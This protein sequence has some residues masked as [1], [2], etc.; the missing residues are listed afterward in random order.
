MYCRTLNTHCPLVAPEM[1][2]TRSL[3]PVMFTDRTGL[4]ERLLETCAPALGSSAHPVH[5][6]WPCRFE[7]TAYDSKSSDTAPAAGPGGS[8][9]KA[10][11]TRAATLGRSRA[12]TTHLTESADNGPVFIAEPLLI[13]TVRS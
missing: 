6:P 1:V 12:A 5:P 8:A 2:W 11:S 4:N 7:P 9:R 10:T 3:A 13:S